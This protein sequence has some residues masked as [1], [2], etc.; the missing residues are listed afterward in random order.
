MAKQMSFDEEAHR[1]LKQGM[2]MLAE[3]VK[4]RLGPKGVQRGA[5]QA[6]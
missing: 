4:V 1:C 3:V 2:N 5:G 6:F